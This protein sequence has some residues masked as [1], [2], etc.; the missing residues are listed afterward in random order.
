MFQLLDDYHPEV[1]EGVTRFLEV[2]V[3]LYRIWLLG[4]VPMFVD[5]SV[6]LL[7]FY[8]ADILSSIVALIAPC[9]IDGVFTPASGLLSYVKAFSSRSVGKHPRVHDVGATTGITPSMTR[10]A[11]A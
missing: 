3:D 6:R 11:S 5:T 8:F 1:L 2:L 7:G 9:Q 10:G 4:I